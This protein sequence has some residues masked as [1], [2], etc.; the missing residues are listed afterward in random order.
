MRIARAVGL[1]QSVT[2]VDDFGGTR[3]FVAERFDRT[4]DPVARTVTPATSGGHVPGAKAPAAGEIL[5]RSSL[6]E[7]GRT[8]SDRSDGT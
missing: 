8:P 5:D 1:T 7:N 2:W 6:T 3:A 4:V